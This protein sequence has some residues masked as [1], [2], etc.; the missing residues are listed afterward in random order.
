MSAEMTL[1]IWKWPPLWTS[2]IST[3]PVGTDFQQPRGN[4]GNRHFHTSTIFTPYGGPAC[5]GHGRPAQA[6]GARASAV[7]SWSTLLGHSRIT[8]DHGRIARDGRQGALE[9]PGSREGPT[10]CRLAAGAKRIRTA[11]PTSEPHVRRTV[12]AGINATAGNERVSAE[13][14]IHAPIY[15]DIRGHSRPARPAPNN[16]PSAD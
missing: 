6:V 15:S 4:H 14:R 10:V 7:M 11:G 5:P 13:V 3:R 8:M 9:R 12:Q 1:E 2:C 16:Y